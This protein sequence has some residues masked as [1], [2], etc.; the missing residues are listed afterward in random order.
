MIVGRRVRRIIIVP[1]ELSPSQ[2]SSF[3]VYIK[4]KRV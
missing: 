1:H 4:A 3:L 2:Y